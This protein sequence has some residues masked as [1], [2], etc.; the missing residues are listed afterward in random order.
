MLGRSV[1]L[2][3]HNATGG[4][5]RTKAAQTIRYFSTDKRP[6]VA[7]GFAWFASDADEWFVLTCAWYFCFLPFEKHNMFS[8]K[9]LFQS[10]EV[11]DQETCAQCSCLRTEI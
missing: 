1:C 3:C 9:Y 10:N 7:A 8:I 6:S 5:E 4:I 11:Y 2:L